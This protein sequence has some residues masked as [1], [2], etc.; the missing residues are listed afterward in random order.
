VIIQRDIFFEIHQGLPREG[1]GRNDYTQKAFEI[2]P[3]MER[4]RILDIGCGPGGPTRTGQNKRWECY[5][6]GHASAVP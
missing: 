2:L 1:P 6:D 4:P 5:R 3:K